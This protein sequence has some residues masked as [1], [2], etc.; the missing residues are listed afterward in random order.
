MSDVAV[1]ILAR[2]GSKGV[3][4]KNLALVGGISLLHRAIRT[5][6]AA[7]I[8]SPAAHGNREVAPVVWVSTEDEGIAFEAHARGARV[9]D[10]P[11]ELATDKSQGI[12]VLRHAARH[13]KATRIALVQCVAPMMTSGDIERTVHALEM[14]YDLTVATVSFDGV[15]LSSTGE[16]LTYDIDGDENRQGRDKMSRVAGSVWAFRP[17]YLE[18][19]WYSGSIGAVPSDYPLHLEI[20]TEA[21]LHAARLVVSGI[22]SQR[23]RSPES[24]PAGVS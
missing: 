11:A 12:D 21:D 5:S 20:D 15:V 16:L 9:I 18:Q 22:E 13:I 14:G 3:H 7:R 19:Q 6:Q 10:R 17:E 1:V 2:G 23:A 8:R 24:L 4:R